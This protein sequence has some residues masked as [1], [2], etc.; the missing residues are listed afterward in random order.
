MAVSGKID[1]EWYAVAITEE[2][3]EVEDIEASVHPPNVV[4]QGVVH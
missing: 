2:T 3:I 4:C 1:G